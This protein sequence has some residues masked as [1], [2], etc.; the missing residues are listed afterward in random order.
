MSPSASD[1]SEDDNCR[2]YK[3]KKNR[4]A[5]MNLPAA[6]RLPLEVP[7]ARRILPAPT[8]NAGTI[9]NSWYHNPPTKSWEIAHPTA[10][11]M[12]PAQLMVED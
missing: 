9:V 7:A 11:S 3:Y 10:I 1:L 8:K 5:V 2:P 4:L 6:G 12:Q